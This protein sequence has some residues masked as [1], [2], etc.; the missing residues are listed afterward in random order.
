MSVTDLVLITGEKSKGSLGAGLSYLL[1]TGI[2]SK[3]QVEEEV[4]ATS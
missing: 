1:P 3:G 2:T 4:K